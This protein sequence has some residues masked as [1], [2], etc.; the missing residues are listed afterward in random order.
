[1]DATAQTAST[2]PNPRDIVAVALGDPAIKGAIQRGARKAQVKKYSTV[3]K[4]GR[5]GVKAPQEV[6]DAIITL[7]KAGLLKWEENNT[8]ISF[9]EVCFGMYENKEG[10]PIFASVESRSDD[11]HP[12]T[13]QLSGFL[14]HAT[15]RQRSAILKAITERAEAVFARRASFLAIA[16]R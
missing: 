11:E 13:E 1:M 8:G 4:H 7:T 15:K 10:Q 14:M 3:T 2:L 6:V 5:N 12:D 16:G 9:V